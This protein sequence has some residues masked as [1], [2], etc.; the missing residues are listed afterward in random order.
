MNAL[1][2]PIVAAL[3]CIS[4]A[5]CFGAAARIHAM[6]A[7]RQ[8][9]PTEASELS[10]AEIVAAGQKAWSAVDFWIH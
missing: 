3:V 2:N 4:A 6:D 10:I 5:V 1:L 7:A 8:P 9:L